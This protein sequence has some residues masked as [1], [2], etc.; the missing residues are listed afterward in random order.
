MRK[1]HQKCWINYGKIG[2]KRGG[3]NQYY[4]KNLTSTLNIYQTEY[5]ANKHYKA[6]NSKHK[7]ISHDTMI[8]GHT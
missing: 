8:F 1:K 2:T 4:K 5:I 6:Y 7:S 3:V